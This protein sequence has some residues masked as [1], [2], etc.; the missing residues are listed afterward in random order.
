MCLHQGPTACTLRHFALQVEA[1]A[2]TL[3]TLL[4]D[5]DKH[6]NI[7]EAIEVG[8]QGR[9]VGGRGTWTAGSEGRLFSGHEQQQTEQ[10]QAALGAVKVPLPAPSTALQAIPSAHLAPPQ[11][12]TCRLLE[13]EGPRRK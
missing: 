12:A 8:P 6:T 1:N 3:F 7:F 9:A 5:P 10:A 2:D 4:A 11:G 13:E